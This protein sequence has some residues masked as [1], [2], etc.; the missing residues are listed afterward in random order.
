MPDQ[1]N[2]RFPAPL[3]EPCLIHEW[4]YDAGVSEIFSRRYYCLRCHWWGHRRRGETIPY[5]N[6]HLPPYVMPPTR[7]NS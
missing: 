4:R 3:A 2:E 5:K 6:G 7:S 1:K